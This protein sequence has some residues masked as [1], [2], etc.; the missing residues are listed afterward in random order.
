[1]AFT[2]NTA[3]LHRGEKRL[4][5][6]LIA[7]PTAASASDLDDI[8]LAKAFS[9]DFPA[10]PDSIEFAR[11]AE[12][13]VQSSAVL[14]D[15][16]HAYKKTDPLKIPFS[17]Q[18]HHNDSAYCPQGALTLLQLAARLHAFV[19]PLN[20]NP[21]EAVAS[22][23][24]VRDYRQGDDA[25]VSAK[26]QTSFEVNFDKTQFNRIFSPLTARLELIFASSSDVGVSCNGYVEEVSVKLNGPFLRGPNNSFNLP[27][28]ANYSFTFVHRPSHGNARDFISGFSAQADAY[29]ADVRDRFYNTAD[30]VKLAN[31]QGFEPAPASAATASATTQAVPVTQV[32][33]N[34]LRSEA[35]GIFNLDTQTYGPAYYKPGSDKPLLLEPPTH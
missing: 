22:V 14:P 23:R 25:S 12:Y 27:T 18:L 19:L 9:I 6:R 29:A 4:T 15:G 13:V 31:Y 7:M 2:P 21:N 30:M 17:F 35:R 32:P 1:M 28:S 20:L 24:Q 8:R 3:A 33:T 11:R 34:S 5:G 26:A 16:V 10:M